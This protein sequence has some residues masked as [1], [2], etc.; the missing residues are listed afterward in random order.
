MCLY[1]T[2][3]DLMDCSPPAGL[4]CPWGFSRQE[5]W[6]GLPFLSP[7]DLPNPGIESRSPALQADSLQSEL[8]QPHGRVTWRKV[9]R[10]PEEA[11]VPC[12]LASYLLV[13]P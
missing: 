6:S 12:T 10:L 13:L 4:L 11:K 8:P 2:L 1:L 3:C 5:C 9:N 7:G